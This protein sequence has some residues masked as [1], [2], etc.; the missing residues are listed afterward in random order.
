MK[1]ITQRIKHK[2]FVFGIV[3]GLTAGF[4]I[5]DEFYFPTFE[6]IEALV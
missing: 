3:C 6:K 5:R 1:T 4:F 2:N